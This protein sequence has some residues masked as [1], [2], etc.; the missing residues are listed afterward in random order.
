M[1]EGELQKRMDLLL[2]N[3]PSPNYED[4]YKGYEQ[5]IK[6]TKKIIEEAKKDRPLTEQTWNAT[7]NPKEIIRKLI[8]ELDKRAG[9]FVKWF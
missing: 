7:D 2:E 6:D 9:W 4:D 3:Y 5:A 1:T 8:I